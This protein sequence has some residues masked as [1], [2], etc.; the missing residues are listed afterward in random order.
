[1]CKLLFGVAFFIQNKRQVSVAYRQK[2]ILGG[3]NVAL[4]QLFIQL[5]QIQTHALEI[6]LQNTAVHNQFGK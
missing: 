4:F 6:V 1:M 2:Y 3:V 5:G